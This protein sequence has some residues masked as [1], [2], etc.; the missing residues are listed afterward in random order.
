MKDF[1]I[2]EILDA[3]PAGLYTSGLDTATLGT[4]CGFVQYPD[5]LPDGLVDGGEIPGEQWLLLAYERDGL[6]MDPSN[7]DITSGRING[8]GP[9]RVIVP[10]SEP[11]SP[12]RGS[13]YSPTT[14]DDGWD[15]DA[16]KDHNAG[17]MV[18]GVV[19]IR[20]NPLPAGYE[21]FDYYNGGWAYIDA[22][23]IIVY[24]HGVTP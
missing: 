4:E 6:P 7:L 11:G 21:D 15:Y 8:E 18:R 13:N 19:G 2:D 20:V 5:V 3:F 23:S 9:F 14:C 1:T 17:A 10:Q 16:S 24:G 12:D 22:E